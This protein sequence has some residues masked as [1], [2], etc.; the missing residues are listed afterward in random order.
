MLRIWELARYA[1]ENAWRSKLRTLLTVV[2][3]AIASGALVSMVGFVLGLRQ[4]VEEPINKLGLL[5]NIEV[6]QVLAEQD[7]EASPILDD[8]KLKEIEAI[9]GVDFVYPDFRL[10]EINVQH[11]EFEKNSTAIGIPRETSLVGFSDELLE[12]GSFFTLGDENE[13]VIGRKLVKPLGFRST[14]GAIGKTVTL[15]MG[16]L[17]ENDQTFDVESREVEFK[18]VGVFN[19]PGFATSWTDST[20]L[21]PVDIMR[22]LPPHWMEGGINQIRAGRG[23]I[24]K[25]YPKITVRTKTPGD[26]IRV[27]AELEGLGFAT[28]SVLDRMEELKEFFLFM[29]ILLTAVGTVALI[30]AGVGILNTLAMTVMERYQE[31]G[32]Y[33]SI[34]AS[35]GDIRWMFLVEA[36]AVGFLGG[37]GG[38]ILAR[39]VS[40]FLSWAFTTYAAQYGIGGPDAVFV[41]PGWLLT[42]SVLYSVVISILSGIYPASRAANVDPVLAL[43][44]G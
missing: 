9:E 33:K 18:V 44:R 36:A 20:V 29:E 43:R 27:E 34:G 7:R 3:I 28:L 38:L 39:V 6:R 37:V 41:F 10:S 23:K 32:I 21:L 15:E 14:V 25:G 26:V 17:V 16:G 30:V 1:L 35:H 2:G 12:A 4:Q 40:V 8:A 22:S 11:G 13:I 42:S 24:V 31:I 19:P 5:N